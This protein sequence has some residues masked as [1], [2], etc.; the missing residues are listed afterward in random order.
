[1]N[2]KGIL[3]Y[4][5][6]LIFTSIIN[7][8]TD[9]SNRVYFTINP[10]NRTITVP[11]LLNDSITA[12]MI[13]DTGGS[14]ILDSLLVAAH[15]SLSHGIISA[16]Y[17]T[18]TAWSDSSLYTSSLR[19]NNDTT[20]IKVGS[21][22]LT[23]KSKNIENWRKVMQNDDSDG[24]FNIPTEDTT[25]VWELNFEYNYLEINA[26]KDFKMPRNCILCPMMEENFNI[27]IPMQI[28]C[29]DGDT[30]TIN[31]TF[32]IDTG[33]A[34]DMAFLH[35]D[36]KESEFFNKRDDA[37]WTQYLDEYN[38]HYTVSATLFDDFSVD[39][40]RIYTFSNPFKVGAKYLIGQNFLKRFNVFF[41]MKNR[42][43][44]LQPIKN[45]RRIVNPN[46]RRFHFS[47]DKT[48]E[49]KFI[50]KTVADYRDN[51]YKT[52]GMQEGDEI[53]AVN[54]MPYKDI[55]FKEKSEF[56]TKDTLI[57]DIIRNGSLL[58]IVVPVNKD[59]EQGD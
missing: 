41:D 49:G 52:A 12:N 43:I 18:G 29:S 4:L 27:Q 53:I 38:R 26:V 20:T 35:P 32:F 33:M 55:S 42:Q 9:N 30:I 45:F 21:T 48:P 28:T 11:L 16:V 51:Y 34:W 2:K 39:S 24:L 36:K 8:C 22:I 17:Q 31:G 7:G 14:F 57:Y 46:H 54:D 10:A 58:K 23:D 40:L 1:M 47:T 59:E 19:Y 25:H 44:G 6:F 5:F 15:P 3:Y 37:I 56:Y 13:F 50:V